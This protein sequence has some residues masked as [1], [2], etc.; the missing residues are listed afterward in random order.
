MPSIFDLMPANWWPVQPFI[1]PPD[2]AQPTAW[3]SWASGWTPAV[4]SPPPH[5]PTAAA[6]VPA[7]ADSSVSEWDRAMRQALAAQAGATRDPDIGGIASDQALA[8]AKR[9]HDFVR[10]VLGPPSAPQAPPMGGAM[11]RGGS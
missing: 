2:P 11:L 10:W 6:D 1:P 8:D 9:A 4:P 5:W 7:D 3:P